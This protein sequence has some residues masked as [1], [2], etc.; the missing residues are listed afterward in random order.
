MGMMT[1][2]SKAL[3]RGGSHCCGGKGFCLLLVGHLKSL[4]RTSLV[5]PGTRFCDNGGTCAGSTLPNIRPMWRRRSRVSQAQFGSR[6]LLDGTD[7]GVSVSGRV[8][9]WAPAKVTAVVS[10]GD[11]SAETPGCSH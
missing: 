6:F 1:T 10:T 4:S 7:C 3:P 8:A 5:L 2:G 11:Y 9:W